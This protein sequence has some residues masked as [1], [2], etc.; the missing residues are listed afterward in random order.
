VTTPCAVIKLVTG[1]AIVVAIKL[2]IVFAKLGLVGV[3]VL[4]TLAR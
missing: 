1:K 3:A 2:A 4:R